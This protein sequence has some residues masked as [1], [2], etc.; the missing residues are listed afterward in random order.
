M[1]NVLIGCE[2]S[3]IVRDEFAA[4]GYN[5]WSCDFL[6]TERAGQHL[7]CDVWN[8]L[9]HNLKW[10][11]AIFFPDC[12]F[13]TVAQAKWYYHPEDKHLPF[14]ERRPH[15]LYPDRRQHQQQAL[16][17]VADLLEQ[18]IEYIALENPIGKISTAI[19]KP[20]Q[21]VH[22]YMFGHD[23]SKSTC[24]WL[25]NLPLLTPTKMIPPRIIEGGAKRWGNQCPSGAEKT[26]PSADRWKI[27]SRTFTGIA[28]AMARQYHDYFMNQ[29][30][31]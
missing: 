29:L 27:R 9:N 15:P 25:K 24:L 16:D 2:F 5:A 18:D 7:Q 23:A 14:G 11:L 1:K 17:F 6:P 22:P 13:L 31:F 4:L 8:A 19:R 10:D 20:D 3:G 12:T 21:I 30:P 28:K 26:G